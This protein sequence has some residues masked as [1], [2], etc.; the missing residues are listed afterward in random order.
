MYFWQK[1]PQLWNFGLSML[2]FLG[3]P[4]L[5]V[6]LLIQGIL[7]GREK[8]KNAH[9]VKKTAVL[10]VVLVSLLLFPS[11]I[12]DF[13]K[14]EAPDLLVAQYEGVANCTSTLRLKAG[15][16]F[17]KSS[18]CFGMDE[19]SGSYKM[20]GDTIRLTF[21]E[22]ISAHEKYAYA[23]FRPALKA[24]GKEILAYYANSAAK[25]SYPMIIYEN[26][27]R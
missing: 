24:Q 27:L 4:V 7:L 13:T 10:L 19:K 14:F 8:S 16:R 11:G 5:A 2:L 12:I 20:V 22:E 18:A 17:V 6:I 21:D 3:V 26:K 9:R 15:E 1:L 25:D 23:V